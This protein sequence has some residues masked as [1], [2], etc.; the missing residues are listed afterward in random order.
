M[1]V[2][3]DFVDT[4]ISLYREIHEQ[5]R[6]EVAGADP[7][8]LTRELAPG[9]NSISTLV[10]HV[11]GSEGDVVR[12]VRGL[13]SDRDRTAEFTMRIAD[14]D[15]LLHRIDAADRLLMEIGP[16]I[17]D[18][19]LTTLR[20]RPNAIRH[21]EPRPGLFLLLA[22]YG[23]AREHLAHLELTKQLAQTGRE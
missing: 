17:T 8:L 18:E 10:I 14:P 4:F 2:G 11:L 9:T 1:A 5:L 22:S 15:E 20:T 12:V 3:R 21:S 6:Q 19:D 23:H 7:P 16:G 13:A